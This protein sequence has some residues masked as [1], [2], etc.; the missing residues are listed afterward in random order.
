MGFKS[1]VSSAV[2]N[3][4]RW[5]DKNKPVILLV[6][7]I[8]GLLTT[9]V[10]AVKS[11]P[12]AVKKIEDAE[13]SLAEIKERY[14]ETVPEEKKQAKKEKVDLYLDTAKELGILY[15]PAVLLATTS[16]LCLIR[17]HNIEHQRFTAL[18]TA[19]QISDAARKEYQNKVVEFLG[20]R[21]ETEIR[22]AIAKDKVKENPPDKESDEYLSNIDT[23][24]YECTSGRYFRSNATRLEKIEN[25]LNKKLRIE[26]YISLNE[27]YDALN[28]HHTSIGNDLGWNIKDGEIDM[29]M[30]M[31]LNEDNVPM[32]I[33]DHLNP[34]VY[35]YQKLY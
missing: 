4:G 11:T 7:G 28:L 15:G 2:K 29:H 32:L 8:T 35:D 21:K 27:F 6:V 19:Y 18:A 12:K 23:L 34:P 13:K 24:A 25:A 9:T 31:T 22:D 26:D 3:T 20:K 10:L 1:S 30:T 5:C 33:V 16:T 17:S 14:D